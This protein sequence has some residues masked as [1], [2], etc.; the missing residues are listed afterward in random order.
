MEIKMESQT[1]E[2]YEEMKR[3]IKRVKKSEWNIHTCCYVLG[4]IHQAALDDKL[5]E[6]QWKEL[7]RMIPIAPEERT[8]INW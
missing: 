8:K 6:E 5:E 2:L 7:S 3:M 1:N 4:L